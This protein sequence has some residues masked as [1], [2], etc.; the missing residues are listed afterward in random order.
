M[1]LMRHL[2][3]SRE[4]LFSLVHADWH[5]GKESDGRAHASGLLRRQ[6]QYRARRAS[7]CTRNRI[8]DAGALMLAHTLPASQ[9]LRRLWL[10]GNQIGSLGASAIAQALPSMGCVGQGPPVPPP[11][12]ELWLAMNRIADA[13]AVALAQALPRLP[14]LEKVD[15]RSNWIGD[16]G[17]AAHR[18]GDA[19]LAAAQRDV[20]ARQSYTRRGCYGSRKGDAN[21]DERERSEADRQPHRRCWSRCYCRGP[22]T[23]A[24]R[25]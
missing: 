16:D 4:E 14:L 13:G 6:F 10:S 23:G 18:R 21:L 8:G 15:I 2:G 11:I 17:A 1:I 24:A 12:A 25:A 22:R 7:A 20:L 9:T 19:A 5:P 3:C